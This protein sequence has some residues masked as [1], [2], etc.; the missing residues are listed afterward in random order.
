MGYRKPSKRDVAKMNNNA[1]RFYAS[2]SDRAPMMEEVIPEKRE[3]KPQTDA[4]PLEREVLK[5]CWQYLSHHPKVAWV[6]R[7][8]SGGT[9]F[10]DGHGNDQFMRFN[11]K[12]G[13][14]D[15][16]GQMKAE[17]GGKFLAVECKREG[18]S[19]EEHQRDF[20][21]EVRQAGGIAFVARSV[22]DCIKELG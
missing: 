11:Y 7:I 9:Y 19:L 22:E 5:A 10:S 8:N 2:L 20:L 3:R 21:N 4:P 15:L 13:I 1:H 18:A 16:I 17:Y 14:S 6:T 12:R